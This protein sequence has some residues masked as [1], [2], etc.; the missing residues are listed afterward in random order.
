MVSTKEFSGLYFG[1]DTSRRFV[2][3]LNSAMEYRREIVTTYTDFEQCMILQGFAFVDVP[4]L[5]E[6]GPSNLPGQYGSGAVGTIQF[7]STCVTWI[8]RIATACLFPGNR[9]VQRLRP[10]TLYDGGRVDGELS[11]Y[12]PKTKPS[13]MS[14]ER[15]VVSP[16][17]GAPSCG[18]VFV[19]ARGHPVEKLDG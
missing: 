15:D 3:V 2:G 1:F 8:E 7:Q 4:P 18:I 12:V 9:V 11:L 6:N 17:S 5:G 16:L 13:A 10:Y 19:T 14:I